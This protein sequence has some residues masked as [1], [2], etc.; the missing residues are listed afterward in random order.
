MNKKDMMTVIAAKTGIS[1]DVIS[2]VIEEMHNAIIRALKGGDSV[3][4]AGFGTFYSKERKPRVGRNPK[5]GETIQISGKTVPKF[6]P[7]K[8]IKTLE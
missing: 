3:T 6:R 5:T 2:V 7:G 8:E 4:L 1:K